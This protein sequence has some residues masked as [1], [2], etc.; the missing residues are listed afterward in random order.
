MVPTG[1]GDGECFPRNREF[2]TLFFPNVKE[3]H[4]VVRPLAV[5]VP[6]DIN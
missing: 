2:L 5:L 1:K 3:K 6:R 4:N